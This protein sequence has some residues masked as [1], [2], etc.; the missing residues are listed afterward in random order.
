MRK[1]ALYLLVGIISFQSC[2]YNKRKIL[3]KTEKE[4]KTTEEEP[5]I[6]QNS[7][8]LVENHICKNG[9]VLEIRLLNDESD[10]EGFDKLATY[11]DDAHF[12]VT[13]NQLTLPTVG[14]VNIVG[15]TKLEIIEKLS[16]EFARYIIDPIIDV[17]FISLTVN[18]LGEV[19]KPG[20]YQIKEGTKLLEALGMAGGFSYYG[21]FK[22]VKIIRGENES[23]EIIT[24]D[25]TNINI[26]NHKKLTLLD[27]DIIY[28]EPRAV[29]RF[30]SSV[31][32]YLFLTSIL[33]S[34]AAVFIVFT[35]TR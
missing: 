23:Q 28:V 20:R 34:A 33:S 9:D 35:R 31:R 15:L 29:K 8:P 27:K 11:R 2:S 6:I 24:I 17:E 4:I 18:V 1:L 22:N 3:L 26:L 5:I 30:D 16:K 19:N 32:P 21:K 12:T 25:V 13:D 7:Q 14:K 10:K